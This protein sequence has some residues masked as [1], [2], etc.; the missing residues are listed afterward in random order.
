MDMTEL[1]DPKKTGDFAVPPSK[2]SKE[3]YA[4]IDFLR[5]LSIISM[6]LYHMMYDLR[7]IFGVSLPAYL[8]FDSPLFDT[9]WQQSICWTFILLSGMCRHFSMRHVRRGLTV[10]GCGLLITLVTCCFMPEQAIYCG[11]LS[12][13]GSAILLSIPLLPLLRRISPK[14]GTVGCFALFLLCYHVPQGYLGMQNWGWLLPRAWYQYPWLAP[15]GLPHPS[16]WSSDYFP[17]LPWF[18]LFLTGYFLWTVI[19]EYPALQRQFTRRLPV[20]DLLGRHSLLIYML[21]Q[22]FLMAILTLLFH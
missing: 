4:L 21:H 17:L 10:F 12:F 20:A 2:Q 11:V 5:G 19:A 7:F 15:L 13:V 8:P 14:G 22:P 16:F 3:R 1:F 18:F 6:V 9:I